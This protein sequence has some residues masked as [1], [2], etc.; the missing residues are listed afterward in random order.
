MDVNNAFLYGDLYEEVYMR[1]PK[2]IPNPNNKMCKLT[3]L[4]CGLKQ[5]SRQ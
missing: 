4:L 2:G 3:K 1:M 5:A